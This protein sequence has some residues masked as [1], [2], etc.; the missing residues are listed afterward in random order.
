MNEKQFYITSRQTY[1]C[2]ETME[3][4]EQNKIYVSEDIFNPVAMAHVIQYIQGK[5]IGCDASRWTQLYPSALTFERF[6]RKCK[7]HSI[8][9]HLSNFNIN[10]DDIYPLLLVES[11]SICSVSGISKHA[12]NLKWY[13]SIV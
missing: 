3:A 7:A 8:G 10:R 12:G 6:L 1:V 13:I 4:F 5:E 11:K 9:V 2:E